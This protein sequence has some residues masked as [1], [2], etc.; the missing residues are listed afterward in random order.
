MA[1]PEFL[2]ARIAKA[3]SH[4]LRPQILVTLTN[5][6]EASPKEV[7]AELD[8]PLDVVA[9]HMRVLRDAECVE[10]VRTEPRRGA[11]EHYYRAVLEPFL[12]DAQWERLP[13][14]LRRQL[15]AQT[16]GQVLRGA[17]RAARS[18]GFD[19]PG[20]HVDRMALLLDRP[21]WV[22]LSD[23]L[24]RVLGEVADIQTRSDE[25]VGGAPSP[26]DVQPSELSIL[27]YAVPESSLGRSFTPTAPEPGGR[28][29][30][31]RRRSPRA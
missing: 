2:D 9:Y 11:V 30:G 28:G 21:G 13:L 29:S 17:S 7:A 23:L 3:L 15:A 27:H 12:D 26:E 18:G 24:T 10:L 4:P 8:A 25:R 16:V 6:G 19:Q 1:Q 31:G 22:E 14:W 20:A 5:R